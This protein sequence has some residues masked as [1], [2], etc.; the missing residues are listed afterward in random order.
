MRLNDTATLILKQIDGSRRVTE[1][2]Q[3]LQAQFPDADGLD[4]DVID[5]LRQAESRQWIDLS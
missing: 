1:I 2:I 4:Q 3:L 5:F